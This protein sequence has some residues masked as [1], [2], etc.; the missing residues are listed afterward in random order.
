MTIRS[1]VFSAPYS[2]G[3]IVLS[4]WHLYFYS[5]VVGSK[6]SESI[7]FWHCVILGRIKKNQ[8]GFLNFSYKWL[9]LL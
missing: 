2:F 8:Y 3:I 5:K 7:H 4:S 1:T 6:H 9:Y